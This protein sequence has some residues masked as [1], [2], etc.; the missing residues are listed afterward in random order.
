MRGEA[1]RYLKDLAERVA[2]TAVFTFLSV[3]S[4]A[5]LSTA[6]TASVAAA[7]ACLSLLK[8]SLAQFIGDKSP[9]LK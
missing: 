5:D 9:G 4:V 3:F 7:A 1:K 6:K 2:A 8:G